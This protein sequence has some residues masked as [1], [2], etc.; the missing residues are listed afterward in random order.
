[1]TPRR[2]QRFKLEPGAEA[3]WTTSAGATGKVL[4][5][6]TGLVTIP[7]VALRPGAETIVTIMRPKR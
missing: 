5:D 7:R 1:V 2:C 6:K 3:A 4:A